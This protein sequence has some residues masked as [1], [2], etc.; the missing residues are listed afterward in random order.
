MENSQLDKAI[1]IP[2]RAA[3]AMSVRVQNIDP[4]EFLVPKR[5]AQIDAF[6]SR[7]EAYV[8]PD[9]EPLNAHLIEAIAAIRHNNPGME[10]SNREGWHSERDFFQR[11]EPCFQILQ[12]HFMA[13]IAQS[14]RRYWAGFDPDA[15]LATCDGWININ[16]LGGLN[17]PHDH[18]GNHLSACYYVAVPKLGQKGNESVI[19]FLNP[20]G[21]LSPLLPFG[22]AMISQTVKVE[23]LPGQLLVFP[24]YLKHWVYPNRV[25][26]DRI[27]IAV[28]ATVHEEKL[29]PASAA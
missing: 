4:A 19:E 6:T 5:I 2:A 22:S 8:V 26:S 27:S 20:A 15:H 29:E 9:H 13:A 14:I 24:A 1:Q 17:V 11:R 28:N 16:G 25:D 23:P 7:I 21:A 3:D 18:G 10:A 12:G